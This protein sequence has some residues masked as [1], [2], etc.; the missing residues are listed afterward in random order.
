M[1]NLAVSLPARAPR[2]DQP[3][4]LDKPDAPQRRI[5]IVSTRSQRMAKPRPFY[6]LVAISGL[7]VIFMV[8][9]L[10][11]I[12]VSDG[13]YQISS[14]QN[15]QADL[16]RSEQSLGEKVDLLASTQSLATKAESLGMV[17]SGS[18]PAFLDLADGSVVG[19]SS[20]TGASATGVLNATGSLVPNSL[21]ELSGDDATVTTEDAAANAAAVAATAAEDANAE[22]ISVAGAPEAEATSGSV[23]STTTTDVVPTDT[24]PTATDPVTP[25]GLPSPVTR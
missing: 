16:V 25:G 8:Q 17:L 14:L 3:S 24:A 15:Q 19:E 5:E 21:L 6:A 10:L 7:F 11:S 12:V 9:L 22:A 2:L 13:A 4:P 18:A 1:S 20:D 23:A